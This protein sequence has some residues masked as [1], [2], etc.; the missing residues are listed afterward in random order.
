MSRRC[1]RPVMKR[2]EDHC[3]RQI[4]Y[5]RCREGILKKA[6]ELSVF[7]NADIG[8]L[9]FFP[10]GRLTSFANKGSFCFGHLCHPCFIKEFTNR[11]AEALLI[12]FALVLFVFLPLLIPEE[13]LCQS[14]KHLKYEAEILDK[15][16][17]LYALEMKLLDLSRQEYEAQDKMR[18]YKPDMT[19]ILTVQEAQYHQQVVIN[20]IRQIEKLKA[21]LNAKLLENEASTSKLKDV[22]MPAVEVKDSDFTAEESVNSKRKRNKS[23]DDEKEEAGS[24]AVEVPCPTPHLSISFLKI[25]TNWNLQK[26]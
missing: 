1:T 8:L 18:C 9:M 3:S 7:S 14:L 17:R 16:G 24:S 21:S 13:F 23:E 4:A 10:T 2:S 6:A 25:Q 22:E 5:S 20:A 15:I 19:K 26:A 12:C 11:Q